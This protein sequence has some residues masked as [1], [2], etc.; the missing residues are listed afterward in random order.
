MRLTD[1]LQPDCVKVPLDATDKQSAINELVD[2]LAARANLRH[3]AELKAAVWQREQMRTTGIGCGV[4]IPHGKS[5]GCDTLRMAVGKTD[6]PLEF[7]AIDGKPVHLVILLASPPGQT[8]PH[9]QALASISRILTDEDFRAAL[10]QAASAEELYR[11]I[12][13][14]EARLVAT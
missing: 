6:T 3:S 5:A 8:G 12:A 7:G 1:I 11:L 14:Q 10:R 2:L 13:E 9:I 4:A